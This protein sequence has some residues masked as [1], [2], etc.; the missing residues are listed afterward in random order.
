MRPLALLGR[1]AYGLYL[2]HWPIFLWLTPERTSLEP[3]PLF[4]LRIGVTLPLAIASYHLVEMPIRNGWSPRGRGTLR[5]AVAPIA[6]MLI[7]GSVL[8]SKRSV[9]SQLAGLDDPVSEAPGLGASDD[10]VLAILIVADGAT[11]APR[12]D[13]LAELAEDRDDLAV[14]IGGRF[15]CAGVAHDADP[16]ICTNWIE[17]WPSLVSEVDPDVVLF[18]VGA[19]DQVPALSVSSDLVTQVDWA[20]ESLSAGFNLLTANGATV[21]WN[22]EPGDATNMLRENSDPFL[23]AAEQLTVRRRDV[24]EAR[25]ADVGELLT[26]LE[27]FER[28]Q[29]EDRPRILLVGDSVSRTVGYGLELWGQEAETAIV[30]S[31]G[32]VGCGV[33]NDGVTKGILGRDIRASESCRRLEEGWRIQIQEFD[34]DAVVMVTGYFDLNGRRLDDWPDFLEIGDREFDEYLVDTY[35]R[36]YDVLSSGGADVTWM[37]VPCF[38][39]GPLGQPRRPHQ[40]VEHLN[41]VVLRSLAERRPTVRFFDLAAIVCP[42]GEPLTETDTGAEMRPDGLHFS[43]E[44]SVWLAENHGQE[45]LEEALGGQ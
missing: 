31:A 42:G 1:I 38:G 41:S 19:W 11:G 22:H 40:S 7:L 23:V 15:S 14:T 16:P 34:P 8:V 27:L 2:A 35:V 4:A 39:I 3:W 30:W 12:A 24:R 45:I 13:A 29:V 43:A 5:L 44:G 6:A 37:T 26:I 9:E 10:G 17:S 36:A 32:L 21:V 33:A 25:S 28:Q 20:I 18:D